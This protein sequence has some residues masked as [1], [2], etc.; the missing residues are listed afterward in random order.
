[1][2]T[3]GQKGL[4]IITSITVAVTAP[5]E[6]SYIR[7][8]RRPHWSLVSI[9]RVKQD[10]TLMSL[11]V[12][13]EQILYTG[14]RVSLLLYLLTLVINVFDHDTIRCNPQQWIMNSASR[15]CRVPHNVEH[16]YSHDLPRHM[17]LWTDAL[18]ESPGNIAQ[19]REH[20]GYRWNVPR[21]ANRHQLPQ[22]GCFLGQ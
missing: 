18:L 15:R 20:H 13:V 2:G 12:S 6:W 21:R 10:G 3:L 5:F 11:G 4:L 22:Y 7:R 19:N 16:V 14:T 1:M 17:A 9:Y 8:L